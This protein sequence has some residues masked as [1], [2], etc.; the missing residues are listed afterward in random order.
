M[1]ISKDIKDLIITTVNSLSTT[2]SVYGYEELNPNGWPCVWVKTDDLQGTFATT[3]ENR[4]IYGY[5]LTSIFP[6]GEDF[7]K[8]SSL[9]REEFA[10]NVLADVVDQI[11]NA[12]DDNAFLD[13]INDFSS[14]DTT[15]LFIEAADATWGEIDMQLGKAKA[16]QISLMIHTDYNVTT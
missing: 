8:D 12:I 7:V 4:R 1:S 11:I 9:Q 2:Q 10:E 14:G 15:G 16:V 3:A 13:T 6:L 5:K